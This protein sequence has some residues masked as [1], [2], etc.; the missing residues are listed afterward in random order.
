MSFLNNLSS[1]WKTFTI[2]EKLGLISTGVILAILGIGTS[3]VSMYFFAVLDV[4]APYYEILEIKINVSDFVIIR[5]F[6]GFVLLLLIVLYLGEELPD[7][8]YRGKIHSKPKS[9]WNIRLFKISRFVFYVVVAGWSWSF[10]G[11]TLIAMPIGCL[12]AARIIEWIKG[13]D[14]KSRNQDK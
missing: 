11:K 7:P 1:R 13:S 9:S 8:K 2:R 5:G 12:A 10:L 6:I 14:L 3:I 4:L